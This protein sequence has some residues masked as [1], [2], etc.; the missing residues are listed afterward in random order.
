MVTIDLNG[1]MMNE[2]DVMN[3]YDIKYKKNKYSFKYKT[4][5]FVN[6]KNLTV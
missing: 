4:L 2:G 1:D 5:F 6:R 3:D